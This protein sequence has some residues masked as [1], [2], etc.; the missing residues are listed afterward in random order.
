M[1]LLRKGEEKLIHLLNFSQKYQIIE[2]TC[3]TNA[4]LQLQTQTARLAHVLP[5]RHRE[6]L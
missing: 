3:Q 2:G 4:S 6:Q 1:K 5:G